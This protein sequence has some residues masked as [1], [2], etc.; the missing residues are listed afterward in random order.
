MHV[1]IRG[2]QDEKD[3]TMEYFVAYGVFIA[4]LLGLIVSGHAAIKHK[5]NSFLISAFG[6]VVFFILSVFMLDACC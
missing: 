4:S 3:K 2:H 1:G 5:D 6:F